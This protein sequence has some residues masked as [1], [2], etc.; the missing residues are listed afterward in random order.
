MTKQEIFDAFDGKL[1]KR[2]IQKMDGEWRLMGKQVEIEYMGDDIWDIYVC[3]RQDMTK[4]VDMQRANRILE[5]F[6]AVGLPVTALNGEGYTQGPLEKIRPIVLAH[7]AYFGIPKKRQLS[8]EQLEK[9]KSHQFKG[10][11]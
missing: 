8:D 6:S 7:R 4:P 11:N 1:A 9:L 3:N 5:K 10:Q 2:A